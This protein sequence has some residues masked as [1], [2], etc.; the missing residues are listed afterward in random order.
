MY[1]EIIF[2]PLVSSLICGLFGKYIG[3]RGVRL[4]STLFLTITCLLSFYSFYLVG[5]LK[6]PYYFSLGT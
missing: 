3:Y 2:I 5:L 1:L 6:N 4:I